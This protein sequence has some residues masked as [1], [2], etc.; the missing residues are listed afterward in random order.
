MDRL[1]GKVAVITG[2]TGGIGLATA[3]LFAAEGAAVALA[4]RRE[5]EG[6]Q[7]AQEIKDAGGIAEFFKTDVSE[8]ES[9]RALITSAVKAFG[10]IDI[11]HNNAGGSTSRDS[12][13][14]NVPI[15]EFWRALKLD[16]FGTF[17]CS[18]YA[19]PEM[20]K[21]GTGSIINMG[22]V[23]AVRG[24]KGRSAYTSSKGGVV[25]LT[26][27]MAVELAEHKIRVNTIV[28]GTVTT[29][30]IKRF[31][32]NEPALRAQAEQYPLGFCEPEDVARTALF[33]ASDDS[34]RL[35]GHEYTVDG[36]F[37]IKS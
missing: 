9:V 7:A 2:A 25:A 12:T 4:G 24:F 29:E 1:K 34:K 19:I 28:A 5:P 15:D 36:G 30:R 14:A 27:A 21:R 10:G 17:I 13:V 8:E 23:V 20:I 32:D 11:L 31:L 26:R 37:L 22:S 16:L 18:R 6:R 33:L 3:K 35:T